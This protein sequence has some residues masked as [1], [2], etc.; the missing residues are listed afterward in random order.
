MELNPVNRALNVAHAHDLAIGSPRIGHEHCGQAVRLNGQAVVTRCFKWRGQALEN[1]RAV[2]RDRTGLAMHDL[3]GRDH[4]AAKDL[5]DGLMTQANAQNG[6]VLRGLI[7]QVETD[8]GTIGVTGPR[9][10]HD[11]PGAERQGFIDT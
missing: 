2:M 10:Q 3:F 9:R 1:A 4:L 5:T 6:H 7:D 11:R 8:A